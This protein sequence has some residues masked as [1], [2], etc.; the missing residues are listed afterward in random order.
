MKSITD[1]PWLESSKKMAN[2][3]P[4]GSHPYHIFNH[5]LVGILTIPLKGTWVH[6]KQ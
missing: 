6:E 3:C 5:H 1:F 2:L 4:M